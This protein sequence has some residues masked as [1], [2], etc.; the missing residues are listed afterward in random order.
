MLTWLSENGLYCPCRL[1]SV[2]SALLT[3]DRAVLG[4]PRYG[5]GH[6]G[7]PMGINPEDEHDENDYWSNGAR[8]CWLR[9]RRLRE[10]RNV[11]RLDSMIRSDFRGPEDKRLGEI[12]DIA[13]SIGRFSSALATPGGFLGIGEDIPAFPGECPRI[14]VKRNKVKHQP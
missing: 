9:S 14:A 10:T 3:Y 2:T 8:D 11:P 13:W 4:L 1:R 7:S 6:D 5:A 12:E